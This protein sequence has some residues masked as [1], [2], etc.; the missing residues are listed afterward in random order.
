MWLLK[1]AG[2]YR[3]QGGSASVPSPSP[4]AA[5]RSTA[6]HA[7]RRPNPAGAAAYRKASL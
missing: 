1:A 6:R 4:R 5:K 2:Q 7:A 3:R